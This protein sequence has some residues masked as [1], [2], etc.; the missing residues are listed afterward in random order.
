MK[1][2]LLII[3]YLIYCIV[4]ELMVWGGGMYII[5]NYDWSAWWIVFIAILSGSQIKPENWRNL[6]YDESLPMG[7]KISAT[8]N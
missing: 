2:N 6:Y 8:D 1:N 4:Y 7:G 5:L 3:T